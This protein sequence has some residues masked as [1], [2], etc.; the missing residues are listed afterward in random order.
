[1]HYA[2]DKSEN[3]KS[4]KVVEKQLTAEKLDKVFDKVDAE[5]I[6]YGHDHKPIYISGKKH[7]INVG[8][9]GCT[10]YNFTHCS[11]VEFN[12]VDFNYQLIKI[13]YD[14]DTVIRELIDRNVP[15]KEFISK[16][17]YGLKK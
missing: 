8:S 9:S 12:N 16:V 7:Y 1:M 15:D 14:K 11:I 10:K 4:F 17:F 5:I 2:L 13:E 3:N 6:F